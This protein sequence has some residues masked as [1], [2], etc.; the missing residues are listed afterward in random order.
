MTT[1]VALVLASVALAVALVA[2]SLA[3]VVMRQSG[4]ALS[5]LRKHR[6]AH[7]R[8]DGTPDPDRRKHNAGPPAGH[9]ERRRDQQHVDEVTFAE[10]LAGVRVVEADEAELRGPWRGDPLAL[11]E[12]PPQP[13]QPDTAEHPAP[14][15]TYAAVQR[16]QHRPAVPPPPD[17][18]RRR[19]DLA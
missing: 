13:E 8:V 10:E 7:Q 1:T 5:T 4:R 9:G 19:S 2:V 12:Q 17:V 6:T 14:S 16:Q 11:T 15:S 3:L 18:T